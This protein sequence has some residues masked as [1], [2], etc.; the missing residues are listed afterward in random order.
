MDQMVA[1]LQ[2]GKGVI[3]SWADFVQCACFLFESYGGFFDVFQK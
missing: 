3:E 1:V 2:D